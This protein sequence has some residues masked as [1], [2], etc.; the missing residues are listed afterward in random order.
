MTRRPRALV[1]PLPPD[2]LRRRT[3][4]A[5]L[6]A[7]AVGGPGLLVSPRGARAQ[8]ASAA[9][10]APAA[11]SGPSAPPA[12]PALRLG[13]VPYL[14]TRAI[15]QVFEPL[16][17][18]LQQQLAQP[19]SVL[20]APDLRQ[21]GLLM[22][23]GEYDLAF[24]PIHFMRLAALDW[25]WRIVAQAAVPSRV[26]IVQRRGGGMRRAADL[27][28]RRLVSLDRHAITSL[29]TLDWLRANGLEPGRDLTLEFI[30]TASSTMRALADPQ[31]DALALIDSQLPEFP[32]DL[33]DGVEVAMEVAPI[34]SP[35]YAVHPRVGARTDAVAQAL[36]AFRG[37][38]GATGTLSRAP[39]A[40]ASMA[41][42]DP[43]DRHARQLRELLR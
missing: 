42:S 33:R 23:A 31:V 29:T 12:Q 32:D 8:A 19:V 13:L 9:L 25:G 4:L 20:T 38:A 6:G 10:A 28:G 22:R 30:V 14:S 11:P 34:P 17:A 7:L 3:G 18:H 43:A 27:R 40:A 36:L 15:A 16:R 1:D 21:F 39:I 24:A 2:R 35:G 37:Q 26:V 41:D 5:V